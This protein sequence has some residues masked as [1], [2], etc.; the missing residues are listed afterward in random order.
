[1]RNITD[2]QAESLALTLVRSHLEDGIEDDAL[3]EFVSEFMWDMDPDG[4]ATDE[5]LQ[6]VRTQVNEALHNIISQ[7]DNE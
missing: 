5:D 6:A 1:M 3:G 4:E 7:F 2:E